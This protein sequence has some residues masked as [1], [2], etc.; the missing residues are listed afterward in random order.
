[1]QM[2]NLFTIPPIKHLDLME[3]NDRY[4]CLAHLCE[5]SDYLNYFRNK[6][7]EGKIVIL[8]NGAA[9]ERAM[10]PMKLWD[11]A[12]T[13]IP[14]IVI[15]TDSIYDSKGTAMLLN[16]FLQIRG[17]DIGEEFTPVS[18]IKIMGCPQGQN[19]KAWMTNYMEM[20][21]RPQVDMVAFSKFSVPAAFPSHNKKKH[22]N[23]GECRSNLIAHLSSMR[24]LIKPIH[25]LGSRG[26]KEFKFYK[27]LERIQSSDSASAVLSAW[28]GISFENMSESV[29][30]PVEYFQAELTEFQLQMAIVNIHQLNKGVQ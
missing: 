15:P 29:S 14:T 3:I 2:M 10:A 4:F 7:K 26:V 27:Y 25:L 11:L 5:N 19:A 23:I 8:D 12:R 22:K 21:N 28:K 17:R 24:L 13:L 1:M 20:L 9:E 16:E 30:T 18:S 6:V